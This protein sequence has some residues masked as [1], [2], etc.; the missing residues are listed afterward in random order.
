MSTLLREA[1]DQ[2][3]LPLQD[4]VVAALGDPPSPVPE[5]L[6]G[7]LLAYLDQLPTP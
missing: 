5:P 3:D 7:M 6:A 4:R 1:V 2:G